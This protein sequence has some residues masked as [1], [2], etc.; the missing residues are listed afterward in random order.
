MPHCL[1]NLRSDLMRQQANTHRS[2]LKCASAAVLAAAALAFAIGAYAD[3]AAPPKTP[4]KHQLMKD[5]MAKQKAAENPMPHAD[6]R[7][8]CQDVTKTEKQN[9]DRAASEPQK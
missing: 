2:N 8:A 3:D 7:K 5:C 6:V 1:L 4:S 9:D